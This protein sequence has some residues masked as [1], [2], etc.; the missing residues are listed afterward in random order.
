MSLTVASRASPALAALSMKPRLTSL[1]SD[2]PR[3]RRVKPITLVSGVRSSWL[4]LA[5]KSLLT[6]AAASAAARAARRSASMALRLVM[7]RR[8]L[9]K[10]TGSPAPLRITE[11]LPSTQ[12]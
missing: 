5:R 4:I 2:C 11:G 8:A 10:A 9:V 12:T 6:A 3:A 7:S 1:R